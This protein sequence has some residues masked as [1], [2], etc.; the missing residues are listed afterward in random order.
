MHTVYGGR[1]IATIARAL[2]ASALYTAVLTLAS[3]AGA[4]LLLSMG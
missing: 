2:F 4:M 3:L 1:W